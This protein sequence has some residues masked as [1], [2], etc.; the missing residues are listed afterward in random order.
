[1]KRRTD[2]A[3]YGGAPLLGVAGVV[4]LCHGGSNAKAIK[5]AILVANRFA[6]MGLGD[7]VT[8]A[9]ARHAFLLEPELSRSSVEG[10]V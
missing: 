3:E 9:V 5:N 7:E 4:L 6:Q 10:S 2:Y 1:M 8:R